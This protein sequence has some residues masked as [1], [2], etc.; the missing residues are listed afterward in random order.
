MYVLIFILILL[1]Y[2]LIQHDN[3]SELFN[4]NLNTKIVSLGD[5]NLRLTNV[6]NI[7]SN[8]EIDTGIF[9]N[10]K[11]QGDNMHCLVR[12]QVKECVKKPLG[13]F[14]ELDMNENGYMEILDIDSLNIKLKF[15]IIF[16]KLGNNCI[17]R[18]GLDLWELSTK[19][20][21]N[22]FVFIL[23]LGNNNRK[24][25]IPV[26][27]DSFYSINII[28]SNNNISCFIGDHSSKYE[29]HSISFVNNKYDNDLHNL[30]FSLPKNKKQD[31]LHAIIGN[32][33][34]KSKELYQNPPSSSLCKFSAKNNFSLNKEDC[35]LRCVR[36]AECSVDDCKQKCET[37]S[38]NCYF[39][40]TAS[41]NESVPRIS[42]NHI[43]VD[44]RQARLTFK[45]NDPNNDI[46]GFVCVL[47]KTHRTHEGVIF[48]KIN[49]NHC[50]KYCEYIIESLEPN[51]NYT[52]A[53]K[54]YYKNGTGQLSNK[55]MFTPIKAEINTEIMTDVDVSDF[56]V[57]DFKRHNCEK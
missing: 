30:V 7:I 26:K 23:N 11:C 53:V 21:G 13:K 56:E 49:L 55:V 10:D 31:K 12:K 18:S 45:F 17:V 19:T 24:F 32:I 3:N 54:A 28:T 41:M 9:C 5:K 36:M 43:S 46:L 44:G 22:N 29:K 33:N 1:M 47:Y 20:V 40:M 8:L 27:V 39:E 15:D 16:R 52:V 48:N 25:N 35:K 38:P 6:S 37:C 50:H 51:V 14:Y 57:G 2:F 4:N 34:I 42:V